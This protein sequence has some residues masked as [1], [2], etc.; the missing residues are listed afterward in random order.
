MQQIAAGRTITC[1]DLARAVSA[2]FQSR[3]RCS[4]TGPSA[5]TGGSPAM[6]A[7]SGARRA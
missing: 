4:A 2:P 6:A 5:L 3:S 1:R 7:G